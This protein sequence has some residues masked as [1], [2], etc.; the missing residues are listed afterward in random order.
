MAKG[1]A[2]AHL[3]SGSWRT[4]KI[5]SVSDNG[6]AFTYKIDGDSLTMSNPA[7]Q[8]YTAK[9]D[10]TDAPYK[11]DPGTTSV[12]LRRVDKNTLEETDKRD[13]K[14]INVFRMTVAA[15]GKSMTIAFDDKLHETTGEIVAQSNRSL[16]SM[17]GR[18]SRRHAKGRRAAR[19]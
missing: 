3:I 10:E 7:G 4:A 2:G 13:G 5:E 12:A 19:I 9:L 1:P 11:G 14:V 18:R 17:P 6:L 15:D 8:S 16:L